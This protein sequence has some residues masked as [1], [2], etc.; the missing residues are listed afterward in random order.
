MAKPPA[1]SPPTA[2]VAEPD[3]LL[4]TKMYVPRPRPGLVPLE[5]LHAGMEHEV[6]LLCTPAGFG[7]SSLLADWARGGRRPIAWLSLDE[8]DNDPIRFW[9]HVAAALDGAIP[10]SPSG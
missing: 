10:G 4:A 7:K 8:G 9:R 3:A 5:R 2:T 6:V 1:M